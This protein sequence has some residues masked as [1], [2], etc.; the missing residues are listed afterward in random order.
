MKMNIPLQ[1]T[2]ENIFLR[3]WRF[4]TDPHPS[5]TEI[6]ERRR[7]QL[8]STL[9]IIL[10]VSF[11][12]AILS[13]PNT[14]IVFLIFLG[15]TLTAYITSRTR[16]Y[17]LGAYF[18]SFGFTSLAFINIYNG[19]ATSIDSSI[20][21]IVPISLILANALLSQS[22]FLLLI[23]ATV[24]ATASIRTYADPALLEDPTF[25]FGKTIGITFSTGFILFG[26]TAFRAS[27]ERARL[28]EVQEINTKLQD[29]T[30][31]LENRVNER[32]KALAT[33]AEVS[34]RLSTI[35]DQKQLVKEVVEQVQSAFDYY[36]AHIYLL[37][38]KTGEL[39]MA[40]GTGEAGKTM[41]ARGHKIQKGKGLVGRAAETNTTVLVPDTSQNP[42]W[43]PNVLLPDTKSEL[44]V[45]ISVGE[46]VLGV[47][48]VQHNVVG[49]LGQEDA[50]LI[51]SVAGQVAVALQNA[52]L[53]TR[54]E[55]ALQEAQTLVDYAPEAIVVV[56]LETGL[57]TDPN[58]NAEKLYGLS[59]EEL[60][61]V[62]P[63]QMSPPTQPDGRD[64]TGKAMEK[65][66]EAMQGG[67]P[68]FEW[69]H[70]N[71]QGEDFLCEV[72]LVRLPGEHPRVRASVTNIH[73]RKRLQ[74]LTAM[75]ARQQAT[76]NFITQKI[77]SATTIEGALQVAARELGHALGQRQ[78]VVALEPSVLVSSGAL[79][80]PERK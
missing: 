68:I 71:G 53:Y 21:S 3:S 40:G 41:L 58:E 73:E 25:T 78:T 61:K 26:I 50:H 45:P 54:A 5:V 33:S 31:N 44:A 48:D 47:L 52:E 17:R 24:L 55:N 70:R 7:A 2:G 38:E 56:D 57:F 69:M 29:L 9:S 22:E 16:F 32:T 10:V 20:S 39:V 64:S 43:L 80:Q 34:R 60:K 14:L 30:T 76:I 49:G 42:G 65:I 51:Q 72:R 4:L 46:R 66:G 59:R 37:D 8:L 75:H 62:G 35:L 6:G 11:V 77:Q 28:K 27:F 1:E 67:T 13:R 79:A 18:F 19:S 74:E 36:H 15:L 63:A 23:S 12:W